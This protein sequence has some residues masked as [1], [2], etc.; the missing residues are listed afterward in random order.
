MEIHR[1]IPGPGPVDDEALI[2]AYRHPGPLLRVNFVT[3]A[4]G[5]VELHGYSAG[6]SGPADKRVFKL[7]RQVC[8]ALLVGAGT[9][10]HERY[11]AIKL[12][13]PRRTWRA[14]HGLAP[15]L[16]LAVVS[17]SLN[18]DPG[19]AAFA[20]AEVR[21][22]VFTTTDAPAG[23]RAALEPVA[24]VVA[25]GTG[26]VDLAAALAELHRRGLRHVLSEGGAHLF[27]SL[28]AADL[29]DELC[30]TV[31]PMLTGA[32]AGRI[33]AGPVSTPRELRLIDVLEFEATLLLRYGRPLAAT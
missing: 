23:R 3:S 30:L 25:C 12:D 22:I 19:Q 18:L 10:R 27:G 8:D 15:Y 29:V 14:G 7:L 2:G 6:L 32:G 1:L 5:A 11:D 17:R 21:P 20:E 26:E 9:L 33:V 24:D 16:T 13:E 4:D 31:A 28:V